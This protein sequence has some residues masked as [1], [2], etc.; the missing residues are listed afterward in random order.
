M[1]ATCTGMSLPHHAYFG[2]EDD[3]PTRIAQAP[4]SLDP[5]KLF[6]DSV[7][8]P[9]AAYAPPDV[10]YLQAPQRPQPMMMP[11]TRAPRPEP[12]RESS[13][14]ASHFVGAAVVLA[15]IATTASLLYIYFH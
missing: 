15:T 7:M 9:R 10:G 11:P 8:G 3:G 12:M 2:D 6:T 13:I 1:L 5:A 14:T 4:D